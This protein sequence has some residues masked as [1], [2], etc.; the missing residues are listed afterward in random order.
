[1]SKSISV[2]KNKAGRGR[3]KRAGGVD[4]MISTRFPKNTVAAIEAWAGDNDLGRSEAIR[5]LVELGLTIKMKAKQ[6]APR[7]YSPQWRRISRNSS[8]NGASLE[9]TSTS[10]RPWR[11]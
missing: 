10:P 8:S 7:A 3:P 4:P 1:M 6:P 11:G 2:R 9:R 5:R